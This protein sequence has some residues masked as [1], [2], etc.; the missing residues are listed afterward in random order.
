MCASCFHALS[1]PRAPE[2]DSHLHTRL[3][4]WFVAP[5]LRGDAECREAL[6]R[7]INAW[8]RHSAISQ[9]DEKWIGDLFRKYLEKDKP[10]ESVRS[11][12]LA[13]PRFANVSKRFGL[14]ASYSSNSADD[15]AG[16]RQSPQNSHRRAG[17]RSSRL[18]DDGMEEAGVGFFC[19]R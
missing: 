3:Y 12:S 16:F 13:S 2:T 7:T 18:D 1:L 14:I 9:A 10:I 6:T 11:A 5:L 4:R 17:D 19:R 15:S 8:R